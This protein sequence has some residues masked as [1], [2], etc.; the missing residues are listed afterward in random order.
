MEIFNRKA[1]FDYEILDS[2][3]AGL[4]LTGPEVKST[5]AGQVSL[6]EAYI[7]VRDGQAWLVG[8]HIAPYASAGD[9]GDYDP[10]RQR[11]LLLHKKELTS[12]TTKLQE[13]G[14]TLLPLKMYVVRNR[15]KLEV[16][17]G[18]GKK[19]YDKRESIKKREAEREARRKIN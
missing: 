19:K 8:A 7:K 13:K 9:S 12:L 17:L 11:R 3:E 5:R 16:G 10:L 14:L 6:Q 15:I 1:R 4:E 2:F 18:R